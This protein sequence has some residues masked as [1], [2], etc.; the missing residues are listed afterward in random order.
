MAIGSA[1]QK[2]MYESENSTQDK[3]SCILLG[4]QELS[5]KVVSR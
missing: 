3:G 4:S 2:A 5:L 1:A